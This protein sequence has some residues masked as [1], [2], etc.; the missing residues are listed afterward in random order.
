M[1][2]E[3]TLTFELRLDDEVV[4]QKYVT[5]TKENGFTTVA[6]CNDRYGIG[7]N[8]GLAIASYLKE[9]YE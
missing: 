5:V 1:K 7:E 2:P 9:F 3:K 8:L 4:I 6:D